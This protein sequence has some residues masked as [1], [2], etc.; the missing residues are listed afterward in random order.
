MRLTEVRSWPLQAIAFAVNGW[1]SNIIINK[2]RKK[3]LP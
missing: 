1:V 2:T 3:V